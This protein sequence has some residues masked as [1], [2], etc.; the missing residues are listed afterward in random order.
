MNCI[1]KK[2]TYQVFYLDKVGF[3][4]KQS[5]FMLSNSRKQ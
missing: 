4:L 5:R 2:S 1:K 3:A